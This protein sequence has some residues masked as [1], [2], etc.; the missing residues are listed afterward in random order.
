VLKLA[1]W[2]IVLYLAL[3]RRWNGVLAAML[4]V[5]TTH[6]LVIIGQGLAVVKDYYF[7]VGPSI[8]SHY[9]IYDTNFSTWTI[10]K[11][12][13]DEFGHNIVTAPLW[14]SPSLANFL[15]YLVPLGFLILGLALA[16]KAEQFDT[17]FGILVIVGILINPIVW[18]YYLV[19]AT[20][21][22]IIISRRIT[23]I[24][25]SRKMKYGLFVICLLMYIP[26]PAYVV[27][28]RLF[29]KQTT[30][31]GMSVVPLWA[32]ALTLIPAVATLGIIILLW[33]T[34]RIALSRPRGLGLGNGR[35]ALAD[36]A[37]SKV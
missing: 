26:A 2:P 27:T 21:P 24:E 20:I 33:K 12:L 11:R 19:L 6:L 22:I 35:E 37:A 32:G 34:D 17:S 14:Q 7:R 30:S 23:M 3:R 29:S 4:V 9:R 25:L 18:A 15:T 36:L 5:L 8:S 10:G 31:N 28:A 1:A 16:S 13:F